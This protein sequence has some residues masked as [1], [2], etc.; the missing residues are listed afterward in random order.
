[1]TNITNIVKRKIEL[2]RAMMMR[3]SQKNWFRPG[4]KRHFRE[5]TAVSAICGPTKS[6]VP[7][8]TNCAVSKLIYDHDNPV[9]TNRLP[10]RDFSDAKYLI[11][12]RLVLLA[13]KSLYFVS[14]K[15]AKKK[16]QVPQTKFHHSLCKT[17]SCFIMKLRAYTTN[18]WN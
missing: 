14:I 5:P 9:T 15:L 12:R 3:P 6:P 16:T 18:D 2:C 10:Q 17:R 4:W 1:M 13:K 7:Y 11:K 8:L